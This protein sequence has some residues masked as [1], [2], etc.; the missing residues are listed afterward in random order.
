MPT[1]RLSKAF[2]AMCCV[3][4]ALG[5]LGLPPA[6]AV[7]VSPIVNDYLNVFPVLNEANLTSFRT[8]DNVPWY[9]TFNLLAPAVVNV[10]VI[11]LP[12]E[13]DFSPVIT[14]TSTRLID[15]DNGRVIF[16]TDT[17]SK[18]PFP[19]PISHLIPAGL[20]DDG[21]Y[22]IEINGSGNRTDRFGDSADF[23]TRL[24]VNNVPEP[25][26]YALMIVGLGL[27]GLLTRRRTERA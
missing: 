23:I 25:S 10:G 27:A 2:V 13:D 11:A 3:S 12:P 17:F 5:F 4:V 15:L 6:N 26:T 7:V 1:I 8:A 24:Q 16:G 14:I 21:H 20:I 18:N 22:A 19:H 9:V